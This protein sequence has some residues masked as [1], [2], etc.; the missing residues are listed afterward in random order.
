MFETIAHVSDPAQARVLVAA[1]KAHGFHP[2][3]GDESGVPGFA[4]VVGP[5]GIPIRLP[6]EEAADARVLVA[7]LLRQMA[8]P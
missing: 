3:E 5:Q 4:G 7:D 2:L 6:D 1:L 8:R